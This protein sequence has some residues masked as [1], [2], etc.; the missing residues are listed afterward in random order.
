M[1]LFPYAMLL[2]DA[3]M[4]QACEL[5]I[6]DLFLLLQMTDTRDVTHGGVLMTCLH[7]CSLPLPLLSTCTLKSFQ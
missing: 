2:N 7:L 6:H 4:P 1:V 5:N 3:V